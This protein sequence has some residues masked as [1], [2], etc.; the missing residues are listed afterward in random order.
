MESLTNV[1]VGFVFLALLIGVIVVLVDLV[2]RG[3]A[4][5]QKEPVGEWHIVAAIFIVTVT[6][7]LLKIADIIG[8]ALME[9][10]K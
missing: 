5:L 7:L 6:P 3:I 2:S 10:L 1:A 8:G 4:Y 9:V